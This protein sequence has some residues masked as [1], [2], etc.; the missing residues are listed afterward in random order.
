MPQKSPPRARLAFRVGVVGHRPNR[1]QSAD[2]GTLGEL[3][4]QI[5]D[6][7]RVEVG[8]FASSSVGTKL[9][10]DE[11]PILRAVTPLAEGTDRIFADQALDLGYELC[12]PMPF[13]Q[14]E[15]EQ[16]FIA[17]SALEENSL[18]RFKGLLAKA[19]D[20]HHLTIFQLDGERTHSADAYGAAGRIVLNQSDLLVV[21]WD[22]GKPAGGGG[23]VE[24]LHEAIR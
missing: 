15:Y 17:P 5:L 18:G 20:K 14:E 6:A 21:V 19:K 9:Y 10:S 16:D 13:H 1:L 2:L 24:T 11:E 22:G 23:T 7:V 12:C 4:H 8:N 3:I